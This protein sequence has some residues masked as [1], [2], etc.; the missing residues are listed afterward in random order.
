MLSAAVALFALAT[1]VLFVIAGTESGTRWVLARIASIP[2]IDID[3]DHASGTLLSRLK[4]PSFRYY[5]SELS[6]EVNG[7]DTDISLTE[8]L[9]RVVSVDRISAQAV[10]LRIATKDD[11]DDEREPFQ[12]SMPALP[13]EIIVG[14]LSAGSFTYTDTTVS[15]IEIRGAHLVNHRIS[16]ERTNGRLDRVSIQLNAWSADLHG[17]VNVSGDVS[18]Q[19]ADSPWS[20]NGSLGGSLSELQVSHHIDGDIEAAANGSIQVL[21]KVKP[22]VDLRIVSE[23]LTIKDWQIGRSDIHLAG[24]SSAYELGVK[25]SVVNQSGISAKVDSQSSGTLSGLHDMNATVETDIATVQVGGSLTWTPQFGVDVIL[26]SENLDPS[27][28]VPGTTG[29]INTRVHVTASSAE[30]FSAEILALSGTWNGEPV[31]AGGGISRNAGLWRCADCDVVVG[32]NRVK[33][34]GQLDGNLIET[35]INIDAPSLHQLWPEISGSLVGAGQMGGTLALPRFSGNAAGSAI[36]FG[37]YQFAT[38]TARS[39]NSTPENVNFELSVEELRRS[40]QRLGNTTV[41]IQGTLDDSRITASW[42]LDDY[43]ADVDLQVSIVGDTVSGV[44]LSASATEP[45]TGTWSLSDPFEFSASA[46]ATTIGKGVWRNNQAELIHNNISISGDNIHVDANL[47][48]GPLAVLNVFMPERIKIQGMASAAVKIERVDGDWI[49]NVDWHQQDTAVVIRHG[50]EETY[51][52]GFTLA[53]A[54]VV[55]ADN[56]AKLRAD[57]NSTTGFKA[58]FDAE[59]TGLTSDG[60]IQAQLKMTGDDWEFMHALVQDIENFAGEISAD[61]TATGS[62]SSPDLSGDLNWRNGQL[63]IPALKDRKSV[64]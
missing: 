42:M 44:V 33:L 56:T 29:L 30:L 22:V 35:H 43:S 47:S 57:L 58:S 40:E 6:V 53:D 24:T 60:Q 37:E 8:L 48:Q 27:S 64:V 17:D 1:I 61:I 5:T 28:L 14:E 21:N 12:L 54:S 23:P 15:D 11:P 63:A 19:L 59:L 38:V 51:K 25:V 45:Y 9:F 20:G 41:S 26:T 39:T 10:V 49:G 4:V 46:N 62:V 55:L 18:W 7:I 3:T 52:I 31:V 16:A 32:L 13:V 50:S 34:D 2:S 36:V